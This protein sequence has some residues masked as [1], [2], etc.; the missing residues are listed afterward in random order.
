[1]LADCNVDLA[2]DLRLTVDSA[3][4]QSVRRSAQLIG[5]PNDARVKG[6]YLDHLSQMLQEQGGNAQGPIDVNKLSQMHNLPKVCA[7][8]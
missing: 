5:S 1:M 7:R 3:G 4:N 8:Q 2:Q 6:E